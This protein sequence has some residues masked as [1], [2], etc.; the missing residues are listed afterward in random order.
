MTVKIGARSARQPTATNETHCP[1]KHSRVRT[2]TPLPRLAERGYLMDCARWQTA[3][4]H[5][6][7]IKR[8][9]AG[10]A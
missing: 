7:A 8:L 9:L 2:H 3:Y 5:H 6:L 1:D 4:L 10:L